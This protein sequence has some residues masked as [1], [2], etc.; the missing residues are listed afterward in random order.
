MAIFVFPC[1]F[2]AVVALSL[3]WLQTLRIARNP[4]QWSEV[5]VILGPHPGVARVCWYFGAWEVVVALLTWLLWWYALP[6]LALGV[7]AAIAAFEAVVV[8]RNYRLGLKA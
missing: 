4:A 6:W 1:L 7:C 8:A 5:N 2:A 3:D